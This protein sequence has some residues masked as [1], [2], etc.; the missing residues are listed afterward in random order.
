MNRVYIKL[1][2]NLECVN[3]IPTVIDERVLKTEFI[4][5]DYEKL[6]NYNLKLVVFKGE[7]NL[8]TSDFK[9]GSAIVR[10]EYLKD[11]NTISLFVKDGHYNKLYNLPKDYYSN[12]LVFDNENTTKYA[13]VLTSLMNVV[14]DLSKRVNELEKDK[15]YEII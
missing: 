4:L 14:E 8:S 3:L 1:N 9:N 6:S 5:Q 11:E 15:E 13:N 12:K 2:N 7:L 10:T